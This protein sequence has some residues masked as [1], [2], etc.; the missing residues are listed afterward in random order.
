MGVR[1]LGRKTQPVVVGANDTDGDPIARDGD[2]PGL[3]SESLKRLK[4][5]KRKRG[6]DGKT[7]SELHSHPHVMRVLTSTKPPNSRR[8]GREDKVQK[9]PDGKPITSGSPES[10]AER[11]KVQKGPDGKPIQ[12]GSTTS[13][14]GRD[15]VVQKGPDGKPIKSGSTTSSGG[16]D[17]VQK[18][19]D[20][21]PIPIKSGSPKSPNRT[22]EDEDS[23]G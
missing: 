18:G 20:G 6:A 8:G 7:S 14:S 23:V 5:M 10:P 1:L 9:G 17:K 11:D 2:S 12:S 16:R 22:Q 3:D 21:K 15:K 19:P 13:S 4:W